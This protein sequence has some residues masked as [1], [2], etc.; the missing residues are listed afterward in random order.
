MIRSNPLKQS[1]IELAVKIWWCLDSLALPLSTRTCE[2]GYYKKSKMMA[3]NWEQSSNQSHQLWPRRLRTLNNSHFCKLHNS[4]RS[5]TKMTQK[6]KRSFQL[7]QRLKKATGVASSIKLTKTLSHY[8]RSLSRIIAAGN[9]NWA[10]YNKKYMQDLQKMLR[11]LV[12][13]LISKRRGQ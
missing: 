2:I 3:K 9:R 10:R 8:L 6:L 4:K 13:I 12:L 1:L 7:S 5:F 11:N